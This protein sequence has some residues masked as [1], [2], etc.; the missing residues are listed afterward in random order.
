MAACAYAQ[1]A[2][3]LWLPLAVRGSCVWALLPRTGSHMSALEPLSSLA[4]RL[5][6][7]SSAGTARRTSGRIPA[8]NHHLLR[9]RE[10]L[11]SQVS[12]L[13]TL[14]TQTPQPNTLMTL[15]YTRTQT[16]ISQ[17]RSPTSPSRVFKTASDEFGPGRVMNTASSHEF[18]YDY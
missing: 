6:V 11:N 18:E 5:M 12:S 1:Y 7:K 3:P 10:V 13:F 14:H 16:R 2:A 8:S 9:A 17:Y 15:T 4:R